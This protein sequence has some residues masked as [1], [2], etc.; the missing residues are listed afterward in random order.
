MSH[1]CRSVKD[2]K[3]YF[4][5]LTLRFGSK[6]WIL[7][8]MFQIPPEGYLIISV[9]LSFY[10]NFLFQLILLLS[11][12]LKSYLLLQNKGHV[13]LGILDGSNV[14]DGSSIILGGTLTL[15][16]ACKLILMQF[17]LPIFLQIIS[18]LCVSMFEIKCYRDSITVRVIKVMIN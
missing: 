14:N 12:I 4:K 11:C 2:V 6:W 1:A 10:Y 9:I 7:S 15:M 18:I 16:K 17:F 3:D 13:C 8:T 5:T